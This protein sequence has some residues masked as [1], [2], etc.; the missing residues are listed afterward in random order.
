MRYCKGACNKIPKSQP[1]RS[2]VYDRFGRCTVC[3]VWIEL[4]CVK[5][6]CCKTILRSKP[7][8]SSNRKKY[9]GINN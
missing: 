3:E 6:P 2:R 7:K 9:I 4:P 1:R 8:R 5:C